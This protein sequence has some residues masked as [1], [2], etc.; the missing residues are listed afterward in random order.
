[1]KGLGPAGP[2]RFPRLVVGESRET[3]AGGRLLTVGPGFE[4][5]LD[6]A[7]WALAQRF[8]GSVTAEELGLD[9]ESDGAHVGGARF[10]VALAAYL[11]DVGALEYLPNRTSAP[12]RPAVPDAQATPLR[13]GCQMCGR[14]CQGHYI[15]PLDPEYLERA[16]AVHAEMQRRFP[17]LAG[18]QALRSVA[19]GR[20]ALTAVGPEHRCL[21][22]GP[23]GRCR[24]HATLGAEAKPLVCRLF[25]LLRVRTE[26]GVRIGITPRCYTYH[27]TFASGPARTATELTGTESLPWPL[28]AALGPEEAEEGQSLETELIQA[29]RARVSLPQIWSIVTSAWFKRPTSVTNRSL[30]DAL[31]PRLAALGADLRTES[32]ARPTDPPPGSHIEEVHRLGVLL[33]TTPAGFDGIPEASAAYASHVAQQWLH[34][35]TWTDFPN[36]FAGAAVLIAGLVVASVAAPAGPAPAA[37]RFGRTLT[38]WVRVL[39]L[40]HNHDLLLQ[41]PI[42]FEA[43]LTDSVA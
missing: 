4:I 16:D 10:V 32:A 15:G 41:G 43:L 38:A 6:A 1:M 17:D 3:P 5:E 12:P 37:D 21:Y 27:E 25:P 18:V 40:P 29:F 7:G 31:R 13:H 30:Y 35:R 36:L 14:S 11:D 8:D 39:R 9:F 23:D 22:L 28:L 33:A 34:L 19:G 2:E 26:S 20:P 24:I 42:G